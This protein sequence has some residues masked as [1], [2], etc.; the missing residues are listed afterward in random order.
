MVTYLSD[1]AQIDLFATEF[2]HTNSFDLQKIWTMPIEKYKKGGRIFFNCET[3]LK[4]F[5]FAKSPYLSCQSKKILKQSRSVM[6]SLSK[7]RKFMEGLLARR[8]MLTKLSSNIELG[9][10]LKQIL[11][12]KPHLQILCNKGGLA[13]IPIL[14]KYILF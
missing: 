7:N 10:I 3:N 14:Q 12:L 13:L 1:P 2:Q 9:Q 8:R 4:K 6:A 5:S 11:N